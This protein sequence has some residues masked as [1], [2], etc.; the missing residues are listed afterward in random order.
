M[1]SVMRPLFLL[2][3]PLALPLT[4]CGPSAGQVAAETKAKRLSQQ[5]EELEQKMQSV[6]AVQ[7]QNKS[8]LGKA[9]EENK[10]LSE[11]LRAAQEQSNTARKKIDELERAHEEYKTKYKT[12]QRQKLAGQKLAQLKSTDG[13]TFS[14]V[15]ILAVTP[16]EMRFRHAGGTAALPLGQME[17]P[18]RERL[19]YDP[20]E[21]SAWLAAEQAKILAR[22][23]EAEEGEDTSTPAKT[24]IASNQSDRAEIARRLQSYRSQLSSL[25]EDGRRLKADRNA[26]PVHKQSQLAAWGQEAEWLRKRIAKLS[27]QNY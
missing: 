16:G 25:M 27:S 26:C 13:R 21:A 20:E 1:E 19:A 18:L 4:S 12:S 3:L 11:Q 9:K 6:Q 24:S 22:L 8:E 10:A 15:S 14:E 2:L 23:S 5:V 7:L 17:E